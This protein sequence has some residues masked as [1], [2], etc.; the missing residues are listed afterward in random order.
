MFRM[1]AA[2]VLLALPALAQDPRSEV[3]RPPKGAKVALVVFEDLQCPD[4]GRAA[5]LLLQA[6]KTYK[7]PQVRYDFP[8]PMHNWSRPAAI[9]AKFFDTKSKALGDDF[10]DYIFRNQPA[11]TKDNLRSY[12]ERFAD[13][14]K[15][16]LPFAVDPVG[17]LER[18]VDQDINIGRSVG[19]EH[20]PTIY[21]VSDARTGTPFVEVAD[22]SQLYQMIDEM[23][24]QAGVK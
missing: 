5:P 8:L 1:V 19:V 13:E 12:A 20:T 23:K 3:L 17:E 7:I 6:A 16:A 9:Y 21:V 11:I 24:R 18:R 2:L 10:R 14:H 15:L 22:R 4:C